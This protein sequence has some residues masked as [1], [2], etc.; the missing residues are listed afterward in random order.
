MSS[1]NFVTISPGSIA[2]AGDIASP[3]VTSLAACA[4]FTRPGGGIAMMVPAMRGGG[5]AKP[6][7]PSAAPTYAVS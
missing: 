2:T 1:T 7:A 5:T 6:Q 3:T 4:L